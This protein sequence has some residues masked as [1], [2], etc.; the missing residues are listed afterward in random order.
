MGVRRV[1]AREGTKLS[2]DTMG[3]IFEQFIGLELLR[4]THTSNSTARIR[5]WRDPDGPEVDWIIDKNGY[6][7]LYKSV[8]TDLKSY[9]DNEYQYKV[10]ISGKME[11][12]PDQDIECGEG[13]H[14]TTYNKAMEF[15]E[16]RGYK[17]ISA[18]IHISDILS[19]HQK[20]RVKAFSDVQIVDLKF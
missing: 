13:F 12:E 16:G 15:T 4:C 14:F 2:R 9:H 7:T 17:I 6:Y 10:G 1:A 19:V 18:K 3:K 20:V 8:R 5:F 11:L